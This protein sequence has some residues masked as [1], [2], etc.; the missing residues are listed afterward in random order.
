[1]KV[2][3]RRFISSRSSTIATSLPLTL[4]S[5]T[6]RLAP[7]ATSPNVSDF[8]SCSRAVDSTAS[9]EGGAS[10][11]GA[12]FAPPVITFHVASMELSSSSS[13][14]FAT[15]TS[16]PFIL[17]SGADRL[18]AAAASWN[19]SDFLSCPRAAVSAL[20]SGGSSHI[21]FHVASMES[22]ASSAGGSGFTLVT[23]PAGTGDETGDLEGV[24]GQE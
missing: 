20:T 15:A 14:P 4:F 1:M 23:A 10:H 17:F 11:V 13:R 12:A 6:A 22:S 18:G 16:L 24:G 9:M 21:T 7:A 2:S 8:L 3:K 19:F 5:S